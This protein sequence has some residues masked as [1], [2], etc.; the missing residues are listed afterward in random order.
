MEPTRLHI[1]GP[2]QGG[3][4]TYQPQR[5][6]VH[7]SESRPRPRPYRQA[8]PRGRGKGRRAPGATHPRQPVGGTTDRGPSTHDSPRSGSVRARARRS[9]HHHRPA[10]T[11]D[12]GRASEPTHPCR[13]TS[14]S[15]TLTA[16]FHACLIMYCTSY[17]FFIFFI[18]FYFFLPGNQLNP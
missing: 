8:T 13:D 12:Q 5:H 14:I 18:I 7:D 11:V 6:H 9:P 1:R 2:P 15:V 16:H 17:Y 3:K 10:T 4:R